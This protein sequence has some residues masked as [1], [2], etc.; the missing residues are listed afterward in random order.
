M[1]TL[2]FLLECAAVLAIAGSGASVAV[3]PLLKALG[4]AGRPKDPALRGELAFVLGT[5]PGIA[6]FAG[7]LGAVAPP[8]RALAA[9]TAD[10]CLTHSHHLHL[11]LVHATGL[12]PSVAAL[13]ALFLAMLGFRAALWAAA[14]REERARLV[15]LE[16]M[17]RRHRGRYPVVTVPGSPWICL[18]AGVF[19]PRIVLSAMLVERLDA[20]E[21]RSALAHEAAHLRRR[22]PL[23]NVV[24]GL[25]GLFALPSVSRLALDAYRAASEEASDARSAA[26]VGDATVVAS[27]LVKVA[28]C[29]KDA[30]APQA[31]AAFGEHALER[32]VRLLLSSEQRSGRSSWALPAAAAACAA[33]VAVGLANASVLHHAVETLLH[34]FS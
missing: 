11:C 13:G 19:R 9:G 5:L 8:L 33:S 29:R 3:W 24:L 2:A 22:D 1:N 6:A 21:L 12:R 17:G 7:V 31:Q 4:V 14:W 20:A 32:R 10:H 34:H 27:A 15:T 26:E 30:P 16:A 18:S 28:A 25:A 23:A